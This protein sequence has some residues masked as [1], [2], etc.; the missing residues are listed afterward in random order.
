VPQELTNAISNPGRLVS[1]SRIRIAFCAFLMALFVV[2]ASSPS[3]AVVYGREITSASHSHPWVV[4]IWYS[5]S[6]D[7]YENPQPICSGSL[8]EPDVVLTAAHCVMDEGFYFAK[9][10][11]DTLRGP[12]VMVEVSAVWRNPRYSDRRVINDVGLLKLETPWVTQ[13]PL[14][15]PAVKSD[16]KSLVATQSFTIFGWGLDQNKR[17]ATY[18][19]TASLKNQ[20]AYAK[21]NLTKIGFN[22]STM[23][24]A[25]NFIASE[26]IYAGGCNGDS[27]GPLVAKVRGVI[28]IVG[29]TS[30]GVSGCDKKSPTIFTNVAYFENDILVGKAVLADSVVTQNRAAPKVV[31]EPSLSGEARVGA[32]LTCD[33]G[34]W[35]ENTKL[36]EIT[37]TSPQRLAGNTS[38]SVSVTQADAG[39]NFVCS[40]VGYSDAAK[41]TVTRNL[42][43]PAQPSSNSP[44]SISGV[45]A[46]YP[47]VKIGDVASCSGM[48]WNQPE[49]SESLTWYVSE[50]ASFSLNNRVLGHGKSLLIDLQIGQAIAGKYLQC[51]ATGTGPGGQKSY[52]A[53]TQVAKPSA[54]I[55]FSLSISGLTSGTTAPL[56]GAVGTCNASVE[57][58]YADSY[59]WTITDTSYPANVLFT[60]GSGQNLTIS[61]EIISKLGGKYLQCQVTSQG[62][63]GSNTRMAYLWYIY[64]LP[65]VT[66]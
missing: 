13:T 60:V 4:S 64:S 29:I 32:T 14:V 58:S 47:A 59:L 46:I 11:A 3:F 51:L 53:S 38:R 25:G 18:L 41:R 17:P 66:R 35:S 36:I 10:G 9:V 42:E 21:A 52:F 61:Q 45:Y 33:P 55:I 7:T 12:G 65:V 39:Q 30:W 28:R 26:R 27:G 5:A 8:I 48:T 20:N 31:S 40:V 22:Q 50:S 1:L 2:F 16:M 43:I 24:A 54:P 44:L 49:V 19:K 34:K 37:W 56:A 63:G 23:L 57:N 6:V 15:V 62:L